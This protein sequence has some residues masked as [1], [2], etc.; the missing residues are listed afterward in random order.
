MLRFT[1]LRR[2]RGALTTQVKARFHCTGRCKEDIKREKI[3][4]SAEKRFLLPLDFL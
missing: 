2:V 1:A 4:L 3:L